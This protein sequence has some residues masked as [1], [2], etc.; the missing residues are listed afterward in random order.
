[1]RDGL[2]LW[3][4]AERLKKALGG[5]VANSDAP[6]F[7]TFWIERLFEHHNTEREFQID[8]FDSLFPTLNPNAIAAKVLLARNNGGHK[9]RAAADVQSLIE[10]YRLLRA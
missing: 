10:L 6:E 1:M 5:L 4:V 2:P 3:I 9:H 8:H 7:D